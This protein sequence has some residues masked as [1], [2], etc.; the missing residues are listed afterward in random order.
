MYV[1]CWLSCPCVE[2]ALWFWL[3]DWLVVNATYFDGWGMAY[4]WVHSLAYSFWKLVSG[5]MYQTVSF[6]EMRLLKLSCTRVEGRNEARFSSCGSTALLG[7]SS[8][9]AVSVPSLSLNRS[10]K[11]TAEIEVWF[12]SLGF[13]N[14]FVVTLSS[15]LRL[16]ISCV[17]GSSAI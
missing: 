2:S 10:K 12:T 7:P 14:P 15:K 9:S 4:T 5:K 11:R 17:G 1:L 3:I 13:W 16:R 6:W 8:V